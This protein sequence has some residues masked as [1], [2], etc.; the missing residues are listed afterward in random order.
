MSEPQMT[1][2]VAITVFSPV[3]LWQQPY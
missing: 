1:S 2:A 3:T